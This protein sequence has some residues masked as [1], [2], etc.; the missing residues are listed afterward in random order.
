MTFRNFSK[1]L[2]AASL[3]IGTDGHMIMNTPEPY[4]LK[5]GNPLLQVDPLNG[6]GPYQFPCQNNF[7]L[8]TRTTI[9]AGT[10]TLVNFTG[11]AQ[12]GGGSCQFSITYDDPATGG[13]NKNTKFKTI[14]TIIGG[15]PSSFS[16]ESHNLPALLSDASMRQDSVHCGNDSGVDCTR[17]FLIPFPKFLK[18]GPATFAWTWFNKVGNREMYMNCA[19]VNITGGT[20]DD[21][22][23]KDLPNIF[24]ANYPN[25]PAVPNC[26][27]GEADDH[28]DVNI[29]NPGKYGR[30]LAHPRDPKVKPANYCTDIPPAEAVPTFEDNP[31][32]VYGRTIPTGS[33][34]PAPTITVTATASQAH[35]V[36]PEIVKT[37]TITYYVTTRATLTD[38][39]S[40]E[41][42]MPPM[43]FGEAYDHYQARNE[44]V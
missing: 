32:T 38:Y 20:D 33:T 42:T 25:D 12:H 3:I 13:L 16:D 37:Y 30:V 40:P 23:V 5:V 7:A 6:N 17:Q 29:P 43:K 21:E 14:Y 41:P 28:I 26:A 27:T 15:C 39:V 10:A 35:T 36:E 11:A 8:D 24:I 19:P 22:A 9:E 2:L 34:C 18:N 31:L 1:A 4:G 44:T